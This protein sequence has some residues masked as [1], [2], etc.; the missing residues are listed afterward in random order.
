MS[1]ASAKIEDQTGAAVGLTHLATNNGTFAT[2]SGFNFTTGGNF[3]NNG[4][5]NIGSGTKF[6]V[7]LADSLTNFNSTT[8]TLSSGTY[9]VTGTL[10][11]N[12]ANIV[13]NAANITLTGTTSQIINQSS[14]NALAG[15][16]T[17][18]GSFTLAGNRSFTAASNFTNTGTLTINGGSTF[19]VGTHVF[20]QT[21]GKTADNGTLSASG[22]V[23]LNGGSLFGTGS[24]TGTLTS[25]SAGTIT[26]GTSSTTTGI[27]KDTGTYTQ[28]SGKLN[29]SI[30]GATAG[31]QYDQFNPT[32]AA[33]S[34]T[35][36]ISR[37]TGFIPTIGSTFKIMNFGSETGTFGT[38]N[39]QAINSTEHFTVSYQ[40]TDVLLSVVSGAL[41]ASQPAFGV[42]TMPASS[43][44]P[45][46]ASIS[47]DGRSSHMVFASAGGIRP[48]AAAELNTRSIP[49]HGSTFVLLLLAF[50]A[51]GLFRWHSTSRRLI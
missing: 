39:G 28:N 46:E 11:F 13:T 2:A 16:A 20:T 51:C 17:N 32:K 14:A 25:S 1:G 22:G 19:S 50:A 41:T 3:T 29:I 21:A 4:T 27:L 23:K 44:V 12:N 10:Q 37:P 36:N 34:G 35:L 26:P 42:N 6:S 49:D 45:I 7:N 31:T 9:N 43:F 47:G 15:F 33:L 5:L 8:H 24:I 18:N 40:P 38:V 48:T 30:K